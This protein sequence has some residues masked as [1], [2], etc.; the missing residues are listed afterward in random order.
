[1]DLFE[2]IDKLPYL[3]YEIGGKGYVLGGHATN[4]SNISSFLN[5]IGSFNEEE[6]QECEKQIKAYIKRR[7][8]HGEWYRGR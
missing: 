4:A 5:I 7:K 2:K 3:Y 1:M 6:L 8:I